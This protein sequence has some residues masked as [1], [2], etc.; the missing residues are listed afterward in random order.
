MLVGIY[1]DMSSKFKLIITLITSLTFKTYC[2]MVYPAESRNSSTKLDSTTWN[3][4]G[5]L[6]LHIHHLNDPSIAPKQL[7]SR[8]HQL[9]NS[10]IDQGRT[11]PIEQPMT[12]E[13]FTSY[14]F[15]AD[16]F[17]GLLTDKPINQISDNEW[18]HVLGGCYYVKPNYVGRSNHVCTLCYTSPQFTQSII[19]ICNA[20]FIVNLHKRGL[21]LGSTLGKSY[22]HYGPKL[23]YKG[24]K[25][26][27]TYSAR[28][29]LTHLISHIQPCLSIKCR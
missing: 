1:P 22:L 26:A 5:Q 23:G 14:F 6:K 13:Q 28:H 2:Q 11:Y 18:D 29:H 27:Q 3:L 10:I 15:T 20:G 17:I 16:L 8:L 24:C 7:L 9:F 12:Q 4:P 21:G 25:F 19:Q